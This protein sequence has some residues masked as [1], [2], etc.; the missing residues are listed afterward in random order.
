MEPTLNLAE[1]TLRDLDQIMDMEAKGFAP[2]N[3]ELREVYELRIRTFPQGSLIAYS[4]S[5]YVGC[6][7][8]EIWKE[9]SLL[10]T[11]HFALG[12]DILE[13]HDPVLGTE[14]YITSMTIS[15]AF[16]GKGLGSP[17][18]VGCINRVAAAYPQLTS[19]LLLV[20]ETWG[21][22]RAIYEGAGFKEV[23]RFKNFFNPDGMTHEDGIVMRCPIQ[24]SESKGSHNSF[25]SE[26]K[27]KT[28]P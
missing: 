11:G 6:I 10:D 16:R 22:A 27:W 26:L 15:P 14:L 19:A 17:L 1:A 25:G 7:F 20:N 12:H 28:I 21:H 9:S 5:E 3:T 23:A 24:R 8:S 4:G 13:R 2:G 18:F